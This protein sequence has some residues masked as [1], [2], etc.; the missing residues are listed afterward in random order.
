MKHGTERAAREAAESIVAQLGPGWV[1]DVQD[2]SRH[3][4]GGWHG[5]AVLREGGRARGRVE[6]TERGFGCYAGG[7]Y[8]RG[9][10]PADAFG[11]CLA[12]LRQQA[13]SAQGQHDAIQRAAGFDALACDGCSEQR[14][15]VA[16]LEAEVAR[17]RAERDAL[18]SGAV[19]VIGCFD[20]VD[21]TGDDNPGLAPA[22]SALAD[23]LAPQA[24]EAPQVYQLPVGG[25]P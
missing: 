24:V 17:L 11:A 8:A 14:D 10:T 6:P 25:A 21:L 7:Q 9:T 16:A 19:A 22:V 15:R 5:S 13:R 3:S 2:W 18:R 4:P 1:A 20:G 23:L 12:I